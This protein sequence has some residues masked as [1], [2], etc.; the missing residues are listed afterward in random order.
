MPFDEL[1]MGNDH[2][3]TNSGS[4]NRSIINF[5]FHH[6]LNQVDSN[7]DLLDR[8]ILTKVALRSTEKPRSVGPHKSIP[9]KISNKNKSR[10]QNKKFRS[11]SNPLYGIY[12]GSSSDDDNV[13]QRRLLYT[14]EDKNNHQLMDTGTSISIIAWKLTKN[15]SHIISDISIP[16]RLPHSGF[17]QRFK[18][19]DN[20]PSISEKDIGLLYR[21]IKRLL[22]T[23]KITRPDVLAC[24]SYIITRM[25]LPINYHKD[26]HLNVDVLFVKKI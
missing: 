8:V 18:L 26:G 22:F 9:K 25:E 19:N 5:P 12:V 23:S 15:R 10:Q 7:T 17:S 3:S 11:V 14:N 21:L 13:P 16:G 4:N 1:D 24:V 6:A 2:L 20:S